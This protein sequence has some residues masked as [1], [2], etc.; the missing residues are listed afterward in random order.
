MAGHEILKKVFGKPSVNGHHLRKHS[1]ESR[2]QTTKQSAG[3]SEDDQPPTPPPKDQPEQ[4]PSASV[5]VETYV[6]S[7]KKSRTNSIYSLS[8]IS[9]TNQLSQLTS[10]NLP[11]APSLSTSIAAIPNAPAAANTLAAAAEQIGKWLQKASEVLKGLDAEDDVEW[12]AAGG[13]DGLG[14]V[15]T[16]IGKFEGLIGIY[17]TA[18]EDLQER[19]DIGRVPT[20]E[21]KALVDQMEIILKEWDS[22]RK[23]LRGVKG[24]VEL[25]ME[26]EELW[27]HV[28]GD[29]GQEMENLINL[30]FEMEE[31]RHK[32]WFAEPTSDGTHGL[33]MQELQTIVEEM[34]AGGRLPANHR[35]SMPPAFAAS[36]P[37]SPPGLV[38][39]HEDSSLL[40]LFARMQPLRASLDFLPMTLSNFYSRADS[41]LPTACQELEARRK[42]LEKKWKK[43]ESDAEGLRRELGEDRWLLVFRNAGRQAQK[44]CESVERSIGKLQESFEAGAQHNN[45][46][47]LAKKVENYEA[48]KTHYGPAIERILGIIEK[49]VKDRLT[50][51][52]EI[53]RLQSET[54]TRWARIEQQMKEM[55]F[56]LD[57]LNLNKN[58]QLRDSI[59]SI[60]SMDHSAVGS[61]VDTPRSSPASSVVMAPM[62]SHNG[63]VSVEGTGRRS[64]ALSTNTTRSTNGRPRYFSM[65]PVASI[66]HLPR[67]NPVS[68]V[69]ASESWLGSR[70]ASPTP[71]SNQSS[72]TPTPGSRPKPPKYPHETKPRWNSSPKV[73]HYDFPLIT[74]PLTITTPPPGHKSPLSF[75]S[76]RSVSSSNVTL[77]SPL[78]RSTPGSVLP[79]PKSPLHHPRHS[80][81]EISPIPHSSQEI[82]TSPMWPTHS[83]TQ[84]TTNLPRSRPKVKLPP[85]ANGT[86]QSSSSRRQSTSATSSPATPANNPSPSAQRPTRPGTAMANTRRSSMLPIPKHLTTVN[87]N[88]NRSSSPAAG[89]HSLSNRASISGLRYAGRESAVGHRDQ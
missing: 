88:G 87:L 78:G 22:V 80:E 10:L 71:V 76:P 31:Q 85:S 15:D 29:I 47:A 68:S 81:S 58:Q 72:S 57:E 53:S 69:S 13:R 86:P 39:G 82:S 26:W 35:F 9:F 19:E 64:S 21:L 42:G 4:S 79:V 74:K 75:R 3:D 34:P 66:T 89:R 16:A 6:N 33:D 8:R 23:L 77:P 27:N 14:E 12:A 83:A 28:L 52:G 18:I 67:Q 5:D 20:G 38:N 2:V 73:N 48:K 30:V 51:N 56:A 11:D 46:P 24:Q 41:I 60:V 59:S 62:N 1:S 84:S 70:D 50:V 49:G 7:F 45:P 32:A 63:D 36:S 17:V 65:P 55:D 43:L 25:A 54:R 37:I 61:S 44:L 40:A